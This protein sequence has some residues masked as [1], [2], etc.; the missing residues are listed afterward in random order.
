MAVTPDEAAKLTLAEE[1]G[2]I[3]LVLRPYLPLNGIVIAETIT[4]K[5]LVGEHVSPAKNEQ[6]RPS[7]ATCIC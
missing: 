1:K 3:R 2:K 7:P 4:P 5:D 6:A